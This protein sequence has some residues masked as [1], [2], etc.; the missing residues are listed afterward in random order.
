MIMTRISIALRQIHRLL[1]MTGE[2]P[3]V[4]SFPLDPVGLGACVV[5]VVV[6]GVV[7][8]GFGG[9]LPSKPV[10]GLLYLS[11]ARLI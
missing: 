10:K 6:S 2:H 8:I 7:G 9:F 11:F 4:S 3:L 1:M 5:V